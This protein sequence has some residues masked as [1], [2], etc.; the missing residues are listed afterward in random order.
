MATHHNNTPH[1]P[2]LNPNALYEALGAGRHSAQAILAAGLLWEHIY[3]AC[4]AGF[5]RILPD[6]V[7]VKGLPDNSPCPVVVLVLW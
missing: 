6:P 1:T 4:D 7:T 2:T 5:A 3:A